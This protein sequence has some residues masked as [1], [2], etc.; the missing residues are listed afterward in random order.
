M[1]TKVAKVLERA[2][3]PVPQS[4]WQQAR[5]QTEASF[6]ALIR[7]AVDIA[8]VQAGNEFAHIK[9]DPPGMTSA[10]ITAARLFCFVEHFQ[11]KRLRRGPS[12]RSSAG[13]FS[14]PGPLGITNLSCQKSHHCWI[15]SNF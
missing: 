7:F 9:G 11:D 6:H 8:L 15:Q 13:C 14:R 1:A 5:S 3:T 12:I 4:A 10:D 2:R